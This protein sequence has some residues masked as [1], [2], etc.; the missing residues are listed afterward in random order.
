MRHLSGLLLVVSGVG[1]ATVGGLMTFAPS[2][3]FGSNG[4][5]IGSDPNLLSEI[6]GPGGVLFITGLVLIAAVMFR[7]LRG[8]ASGVAAVVF[9]GTALG[10]VVSLLAEGMPAPSLQAAFGLE[11]ILGGLCV[12]LAVSLRDQ[13]AETP[14]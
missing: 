13:R 12:V 4:V 7:Q 14:S 1:L 3:L 10:R 5:Q 8:F 6:R 9:L 2:A 11:V